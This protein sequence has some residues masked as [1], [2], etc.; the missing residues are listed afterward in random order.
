MTAEEVN[1]TVEDA[2]L[3]LPLVR[4]IVRDAVDLKADVLARQDRLLELRER[5]PD[6]EEDQSPYSEEVQ[7]MEQSLQADENRIGGFADELEEVGA[8]LMDAQ[9]G[10]VE[11]ASTLDGRSVR[12]SWMYDEPTVSFWRDQDDLPVDRKPLELTE[13]G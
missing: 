3:R 1:F 10:L 5:Y 7:D 6:N 11:F 8:E 13:A 9:T 2:N 4:A 12:L